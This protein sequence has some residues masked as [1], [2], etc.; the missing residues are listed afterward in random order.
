MPQRAA[1]CW[2]FLPPREVHPGGGRYTCT[3]AGRARVGAA[4]TRSGTAMTPMRYDRQGQE[5]VE[6]APERAPVAPPE[7]SPDPDRRGV[8]A[9]HRRRGRGLRPAQPAGV[10]DHPV[11]HRL[12]GRQPERQRRALG[13]LEDIIKSKGMAAEVKR[14][15]DFPESIDEIDAMIGTSRVA[16][17]ALHGHRRVE[18]GQ[19]AVRGR[20]A[21]R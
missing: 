20:S 8:H 18:P 9:R 21:P 17:V 19:G 10:Q 3:S 13:R 4:G 14:R 15:G 12:L 16:A 1:T 7:P 5:Q 6:A 11:D 2:A